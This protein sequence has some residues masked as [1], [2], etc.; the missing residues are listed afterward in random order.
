VRGVTTVNSISVARFGTTYCTST[1]YK[2]T[3]VKSLKFDILFVEVIRCGRI[4]DAKFGSKARRGWNIR[5]YL[6]LLDSSLQVSSDIKFRGY[7][8]SDLLQLLNRHFFLVGF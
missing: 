8:Y 4:V 6:F 1:R 7:S 5:G 3:F 2:T